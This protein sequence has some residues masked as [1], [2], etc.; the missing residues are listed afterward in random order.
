[1]I[2]FLQNID[3]YGFRFI[4][5]TC[6]NATLDF[7]FPWITKLGSGK[8]IF[9]LSVII[10]SFK[11]KE[12]KKAGILLFAG[13]GSAYYIVQAI[14]HLVA[15]PRPFDVLGAVH[16]LAPIGGYSF[17]SGHTTTAFLAAFILSRYFKWWYIFYFVAVLVGIS[18]IYVGVHYPSDVIV[19]AIL[20]TLIGGA[21][22][23][24][25]ENITKERKN[26][27]RV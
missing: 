20:G 21:L 22:V 5:S 10:L 27:D 6:S 8:F 19:G 9:L 25:A 4:N 7:L 15:R 24:T 1:M 26:D 13:L 16:V 3:V 14:K 12:A 2:E 23:F 17:A 18:R 11:R